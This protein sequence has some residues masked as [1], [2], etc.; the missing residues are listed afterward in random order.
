MKGEGLSF[1]ERL[2]LYGELIKI[3]HTIFA[4]PFG[5]A[6]LIMLYKKPPSLE[7]ILY[8]VLALVSARTFGMV[9]NRWIDKPFDEKNPRTKM[10]P[11]AR[12][13]VKEGELLILSL[14]SGLTFVFF[15]YKLN[16]LAFIL[17]PFVLLLLVFYPSSKRFIHF[18]HFVLGL[19]YFL[20]PIAIDI[21]LN[22]RISSL[23]ITL[24]IAMASWVSGFDILYALQDY[25]FDKRVGLKSLP[26]KLGIKGSLFVART[27]HFLTY[28]FL[29][30]SGW[31]Y[32]KSTWFYYLG[33]SVLALFLVY[34][35]SLIKEN[36][37]SKINKAFFT[38]NGFVSILFFLILLI[39]LF[40]G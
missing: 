27:L 15:C 5:L 40:L 19:V 36:D 10:W 20:I 30:I 34:E 32:P 31:L 17:S 7:K 25:E 11:H 21:A 37:L 8:I 28:V 16:H 18:P 6:S 24:G 26:V 13:L 1:G 4:L 35:H 38:V 9:V 39:N 14:L 29:L 12:G 2:R 22:E 3:E 23:A 33:V